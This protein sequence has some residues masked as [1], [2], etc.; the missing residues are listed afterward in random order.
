MDMA[1]FDFF[2]ETIETQSLLFFGSTTHKIRQQLTKNWTTT[3]II[4]Q[5]PDGYDQPCDTEALFTNFSETIKHRNL[6][7]LRPPIDKTLCETGKRGDRGLGG[8]I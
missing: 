7:R 6:M 4:E 1:L 5:C 2:S 3:H 8:T